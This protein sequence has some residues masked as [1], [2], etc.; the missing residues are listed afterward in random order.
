M[1]EGSREVRRR[2]FRLLPELDRRGREIVGLRAWKPFLLKGSYGE[3]FLEVGRCG[4]SFERFGKPGEGVRDKR[5]RTERGWGKK[6]GG[7][8]QRQDGGICEGKRSVKI[9]V[10]TIETEDLIPINL[11]EIAEQVEGFDPLFVLSCSERHHFR[12]FMR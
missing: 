5:G 10:E 7:K 1:L 4:L 2:G 6:K 11:A 8:G 9:E 12:A 3:S